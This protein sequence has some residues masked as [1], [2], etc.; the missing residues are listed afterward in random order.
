MGP[1]AGFGVAI[2]GMRSTYSA[3]VRPYSYLLNAS[4]SLTVHRFPSSALYVR[5]RD[6]PPMF[7][8]FTI[9][10]PS[11]CLCYDYRV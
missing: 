5:V 9:T 4:S 10:S 8:P 3:I 2:C 1:T 6:D 7:L 11:Q